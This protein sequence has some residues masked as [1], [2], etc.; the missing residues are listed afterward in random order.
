MFVAVIKDVIQSERE[1]VYYSVMK[2]LDEYDNQSLPMVGLDR[3]ELDFGEVRYGMSKTLQIRIA[4]TGKVIAQFR[5]VP[6]LDEV[7]V[8]LFLFRI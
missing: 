7:S 8:L 1:K 5:L 2:R 4:N 6:K 3:T